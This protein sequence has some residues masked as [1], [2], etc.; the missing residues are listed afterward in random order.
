MDIVTQ[1]L[2]CKCIPNKQA[3]GDGDKEKFQTQ[4]GTHPHL[5]D[6]RCAIINKS[7]L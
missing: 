7:L 4:N 2:I 3:R 6:N 1:F 5:G